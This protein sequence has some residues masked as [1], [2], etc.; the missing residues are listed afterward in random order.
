MALVVDGLE[1]TCHENE[2]EKKGGDPF[3]RPFLGRRNLGHVPH[4][5]TGLFGGSVEFKPVRPG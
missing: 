5:T 2:R 4:L 1:Q 3:E